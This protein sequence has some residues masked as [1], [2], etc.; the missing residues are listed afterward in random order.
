MKKKS[1][2]LL[3]CLFCFA[4]Q[5]IQSQTSPVENVLLTQVIRA[6]DPDSGGVKGNFIEFK[7]AGTTRVNPNNIIVAL[8]KNPSGSL[9]GVVPD[10]TYTINYVLEPGE[11]VF[12]KNPTS[13]FNN[14][15]GPFFNVGNVTDFGNDNDVIII[16]SSSG[17]NAW[18]DRVDTFTKIVKNTCYVR[19]D[20]VMNNNRSFIPNEWTAFVDNRLTPDRRLSAGGP[21]RLY[22]DPLIRDLK[23]RRYDT[24]NLRVGIHNL[25]PTETAV[26]GFPPTYSNGY[27]DR[28]R[29]MIV[30]MSYFSLDSKN[31]EARSVVVKNN[32]ILNVISGSLIVTDS[33]TIENN[34]SIRLRLNANLVQTHAGTQNVYGTGKLY[35][36][37]TSIKESVY[38]YNYFSSPVNNVGE[39]VFTLEKILRD[40][41]GSMPTAGEPK[42]ITFVDTRDGDKTD[43]I[44][45]AHRWIY[46][47]TNKGDDTS[48]F[49]LKKSTGNFNSVDGFTMKGPGEIQ[50]YI[51][52]GT[53][54]DGDLSVSISPDQFYL[55]GNP[56]PSLLH[57]T[58]FIEDNLSATDGAIY[59]WDHI[60]VAEEGLD[61]HY[62]GGYI[63]GYAVQNLTTKLRADFYTEN[64]TDSTIGEPY[65]G[66]GIY[67]TPQ[68]YIPI[69]Q[70][71]FVSGNG[72]GGTVTFKNTQ[73]RA[74]DPSVTRLAFFKTKKL[75]NLTISNQT[76]TNKPK[77]TINGEGVDQ[78]SLLMPK[79]KLGINYTNK[80]NRR[81][82]QQIG[83]TFDKNNSFAYEPGYDA[84][85]V[86]DGETRAAWKFDGDDRRFVITGVS[87]IT[88]NLEVPLEIKVGEGNNNI[89]LSI[90]I[91]EWQNIDREVY[92][93]DKLT[94]QTQPLDKG[95]AYLNL[96]SGTYTDR[97][98]IAF[99]SHKTL[100][101][102]AIESNSITV[103]ST[104]KHIEINNFG[105]S[106][107]K[108]VE[109]YNISGQK[110]NEWK[111]I[112]NKRQQL[113]E[114][115]NLPKQV[116]IVKLITNKG[117]LSKKFMI[118]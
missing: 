102:E 88:E 39:N 68:L 92:L 13:T 25:G 37:Q 75:K 59:Y 58:K 35:T 70:G 62:Y 10:A 66:P 82:H 16:T 1:K 63:G 28:S 97:F 87:E 69:A 118:E 43:P 26:F 77:E 76:T 106:I 17:T 40:G 46:S 95:M 84:V 19:K 41:T 64:N 34:S 117:S 93:L 38:L 109:L 111:N 29:L 105:N 103:H 14:H 104:S 36:E 52:M 22:N 60:G 56:Y 44:T 24:S 6:D 108:A 86:N 98:A 81:L 80:E 72:T 7:N 31:L 55:V 67:V 47:F 110:M 101:S 4:F 90:N 27:P 18:A 57:A 78:L 2:L 50:N 116:Y 8:Y 3:L 48:N 89:P 71:F 91:D 54:K 5:A 21:R 115:N 96:A 85:A 9:M 114:I 30:S 79:M 51:F 74:Y 65:R 45:I 53:P 113:L 23:D 20:F 11:V 94:Y 32:S 15:T 61:G 107:I 83:V 100:S 33:V 12:I 112:K 99:K 49:D 73:R 42:E